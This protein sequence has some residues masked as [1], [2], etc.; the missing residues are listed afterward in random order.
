MY[1][2]NITVCLSAVVV[3][4]RLLRLLLYSLALFGCR[5]ILL[6]DK[7]KIKIYINYIITFALV[8]RKIIS[9]DNTSIFFFFPHLLNR[10]DL[11]GLNNVTGTAH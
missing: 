6:F 8:E 2:Y 11:Y 3:V 4:V 7:K 10:F 5:Q 9:Y 1:R